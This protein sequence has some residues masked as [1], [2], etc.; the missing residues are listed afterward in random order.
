MEILASHGIS[1]HATAPAPA[2]TDVHLVTVTDPGVPS[3]T[4]RRILRVPFGA[5]PVGGG[6]VMQSRLINGV[7][8][9]TAVT[10]LRV[11]AAERVAAQAVLDAITASG[12][13]E[14]EL[15]PKDRTNPA[16]GRSRLY[17]D[18]RSRFLEFDTAA[19]PAIVQPVLQAL[20]GY[21]SVARRR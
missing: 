21:E 11:E 2:I 17:L 18:R 8:T 6:Y 20:A 15:P 14:A 5:E 16:A 7:P 13:L 1:P 9:A 4:A 10:P 12:L 19:P 3:V